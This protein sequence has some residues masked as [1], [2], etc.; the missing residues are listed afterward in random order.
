ME[1]TVAIGIS[2]G[3]RALRKLLQQKL[4]LGCLAIIGLYL[5]IGIAGYFGLLPDPRQEV[6]GSYDI[7]SLDSF[8]K[9]L[10]TD[11]F[12]YSVVYKI[13]A[14]TKTAITISFLVTV[15]A[16]PIG[17]ILG[18]LAGYFG[19]VVDTVVVWVYSVIV[20]VPYIL[21]VIA[22][23]YLLGK[24]LLSICF[25]MGMVSWVSL[26][27]LIRGEFIKH[28]N[29]EYVL[30]SRLLGASDF[31]VI[32][33]HILPNV[34]HLAIIS[35]SLLALGAMM[36]EVVLTFLGI[37]IQDGSSWGTMIADASGE[38]VNG[39]WWP[40]AGVT[41][42]LFFISYSLNIEIGRAHV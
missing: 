11:I 4:V 10:G 26:C 1:K 37:G 23:S 20:A 13:I 31:I 29:R 18:A 36:S 16:I 17:V 28:K 41:L 34:V 2:P 9:L 22:I 8:A 33:R 38:L 19:G 5:S 32:F 24:G 7:P 30:A 6:G 15:L 3:K 39:I 21:L 42:A 14:G 35:A 25:A 27:R 40:L 12:G